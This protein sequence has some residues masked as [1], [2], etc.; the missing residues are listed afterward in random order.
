MTEEREDGDTHAETEDDVLKAR[1]WLTRKALQHPNPLIRDMM[2][3]CCRM[4]AQYN[5]M[6]NYDEDRSDLEESDD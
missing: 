6:A 5:L 2:N 4:D 3:F 1:K